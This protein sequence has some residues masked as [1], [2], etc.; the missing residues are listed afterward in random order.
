MK[1]KFGG[2][3][4]KNNYI[5]A[6]KKKKMTFEEKYNFKAVLSNLFPSKVK[7]DSPCFTVHDENDGPKDNN[8]T[9]AEPAYTL[10]LR[11]V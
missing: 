11:T 4:S 8:L 7:S 5:L 1:S 10:S 6:M 9:P 2:F 3:Y